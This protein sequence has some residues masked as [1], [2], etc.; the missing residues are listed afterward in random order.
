VDII[1]EMRDTH[2]GEAWVMARIKDGHWPPQPGDSEPLHGILPTP[3][4][5][6]K[7]GG[8]RS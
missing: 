3:R 8:G 5:K 7:K 4:P 2:Y 6:A 1:R